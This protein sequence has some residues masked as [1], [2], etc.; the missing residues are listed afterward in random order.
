MTPKSFSA[1][2]KPIRPKFSELTVDVLVAGLLAGGTSYGILIWLQLA[3]SL[4]A[5]LAVSLLLCAFL[6][7][8]S[9]RW[10]IAPLLLF[11]SLLVLFIRLWSADRLNDVYHQLSAFI[12]WSRTWL[13]IGQIQPDHEQWLPLLRLILILPANLFWFLLGLRFRHLIGYAFLMLL[14]F[15][16]LMLYYPETLPG[17]LVALAGFIM[18]LPRHFIRLAEKE[19]F[20]EKRISRVPLQLL[21]LPIAVICLL[22]AQ[23]LIPDQTRSWRVPAIILPLNDI[24][25]LI[26]MPF[27]QSRTYIPFD[28]SPYG[29]PTTGARL[30]GPVVLSE[31][32]ILL[33]SSDQ[34]FLLKGSSRSIYTGYSWL[35]TD[36]RSYRLNSGIWRQLQQYALGIDPLRGKTGKA[37]KEAFQRKISLNIEPLVHG[38]SPVFTIGRVRRVEL[39]N[40]LDYPIFFTDTGNL[41]V[42]GGLP[43]GMTYRVTA[44]YF[45]RHLPGFDD[46]LLAL[47]ADRTTGNDQN[48]PDVRRRYLQLPDLL[49]RRIYDQAETI[50]HEARSP[51]QKALAL[52]NFLSKNFRYTLKPEHDWETVDFVDGFLQSGEGYC[53]HFASAMV[54]LARTQGIPARYV[55]GFALK[56]LR[57]DQGN[58][59][60]WLADGTGAHAW[61]ELYFEGIGWLTF[62]PT[63]NRENDKPPQSTTT[64]AV[65]SEATPSPSTDLPFPTPM[66]D[67]E[68]AD[69]PIAPFILLIGGLVLLAIGFR[70]FPFLAGRYHQR[71]FKTTWINRR[72]SDST[73]LLE[74]YYHDILR[75][76][77]CIDVQPET[78]ETLNGFAG[79]ADQHLR[80]S[81]LRLPDVLWPVVQWRYGK[82]APAPT[83]LD[84]LKEMRRLLEERLLE[85]MSRKDYLFKRILRAWR[86]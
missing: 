37:F 45:D 12:L 51:Y 65:T 1:S 6:A 54:V 64:P 75:Q 63:P 42:F 80:F 53:V 40:L 7:G 57:E 60:R 46:A 35:S 82:I 38:M 17:L 69:T 83:D 15:T 31:N 81:T 27:G 2:S 56:P 20:E 52:E 49:P 18:L 62:D 67:V 33:I 73:D 77:A 58:N 84:K 5:V 9:R 76:L 68:A 24:G 16:P 86:V 72:Y 71:L 74:F 13:R 47:E 14:I 30:G 43:R 22:L 41:F 70:Y 10:Y 4:P 55:E 19:T 44:D 21:A 61:A 59:K 28:I 36:S 85:S 50:V 26:R 39:D 32:R 3:W 78:G 11:L 23:T 8:A 29:Y 48:W 79:R 66:S 34:P 25:D